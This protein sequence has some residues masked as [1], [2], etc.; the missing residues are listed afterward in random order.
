M[1][2]RKIS[3]WWTAV[4]GALGAATGGG[5]IAVYV[6]G[7]FAKPISA[8]FGWSRAT[9]SL[10]LTV[11]SIANGL[12][13]VFLGVAM[14]RWGV[15]RTTMAMILLFGVSLASVSLLSPNLP[16]YLGVFAVVGFAAAAATIMP[17]A[18]VVSV[19]FDRTRGWVLGLIN[20]GTG[21]GGAIMPFYANYLL[22]HFGWRGGYLGVGIAVA[23]VPL[24]A[25]A[26]LVR[27]P[28]GF[29]ENRL[30]DRLAAAK[31]AVPLH[32]IV[33]TS[34]HFWL[35]ALAIFGISFATY[36][37]L[38]QLTPMMLDRGVTPIVAAGVMSAASISSICSRLGAGAF[39]DRFFAPYVTAVI[40]ILA[41]IGML[42]VSG[43][44]SVLLLTCGAVLLGLGLGA[45]GDLL[46]YLVSRYFSIYSF[47]SVTGAIWLTFAWGGASGIYLLNRSFDVTHSYKPAA[48][49]FVAIVVLAAIAVSRLGPYRFPP[50]HKG[51]H[52]S[53][54]D[55]E[56]GDETAGAVSRL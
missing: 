49:S 30:R 1:L 6:F 46:T 39:L 23:V 5:V 17:Y 52:A 16:A 2:H 18:L 28:E 31:T 55:S 22:A 33:R 36:G 10:G 38:S 4:A 15:K 8:E 14:D 45:E 25:M 34:R 42:L 11:F 41:A 44:H 21:L 43:S 37:M 7:V 3:R 13:T 26:F 12:G 35:L 20:A 51:S 29:E 50:A 53:S 27:L 56:L 9:V 24:L 32:T 54:S 19:W 40:F 47:G 48:Y